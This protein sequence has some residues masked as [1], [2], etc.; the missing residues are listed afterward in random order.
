MT[1]V[2]ELIDI[3]E[4]VHRGDFVLKL[5]EDVAN[6]DAVI[7]NYVVTPELAECFDSALSF[8]K[9]A[10]LNRTSKATYLHG[11]FGSGKSHFMAVLHL[12]LQGNAKAR[13]MPELAD[14]IQKHNSWMQ[15]KKYLLVPYHLLGAHDMES[16]VLGSYVSYMRKTHEDAP[17][18]PV[19][20]SASLIDE[21]R[22][23]RRN[24]GDEAFFNR[25]NSV[26]ESSDGWG[27]LEAS[28]DAESFEKAAAADPESESHLRLVSTL[29]K[30]TASS[31]AEVI[32]SRG[33]NFVRFD[34]GL[35]II[36]QHAASI[37]Y[38]AVLLFLDELILWLSQHSADLGFVKSQAA[39]LTSLVEAQ[40]ADRPIPLISF[41]ARQRD[42]RN[43]IGKSVPGAER[44]SFSDSLDFQQGRFETITLED[45]NLPTIAEKRVLK[46][47]SESARQELDAA[48]EQTARMRDSVMNI[49]L[50][51]DG[52]REMFRKV[53][54]FSPALMQTLIAVSSVL[55][56]ERTALKVMLQLL[57]DQREH[58]KV[59]DV[60]PV[61]DLFDIIS[62]GDEA[63]SQEMAI[64]FKNAERLYHQKLLP[65]LQ[66]D[67]GRR[68]DIEQLPYDDPKRVA[69][70]NDDRLVKTLLLSALVPEVESLR[71]LTAERLAA[72]NH[73]TIKTPIPGRE[74][75]EVLRRVRN[76]AASVGEIRI[77]EETNPTISVQLS[78][79]D[80]ESIIRQAE[81]EDNQGNRIRRVRQML[82]E[83]L[84]V[85][86]EGEFEQFHDFLW[87]NT[88]RS[89]T[90]LFKNIRELGD[91]SLINSDD[92]WKLIIDFPFDEAGHTPK[93]DLAR[94]Q[95]FSD[96]HDSGTKTVCWVPQFFSEDARKD[97]GLLVILEHILTGERFSQY[98]THLSA[99]DRQAAKSLL[100]NQRS[101]LKQRVQNHLDAAYGLEAISAGSLDTTHE[102]D[103]HEQFI[104]LWPGFQPRPP[105]AANLGG[106]MKHLVSQAL[107][108]EFPAAPEFLAETKVTNL[109]KVYEVVSECARSHEPRVKVD[110]R[111]RGL[112]AQIANPLR[113]GEMAHDATH[114]VIGNH[115]QDHFDR[116]AAE[117][118]NAISVENLREWIDQP[119]AMGLPREVANM[120]ILTYADQTN[121]SFYRHNAPIDVSLAN[122]PDDTELKLEQ[123]PES[124]E[125]DRAV[126]LA[127]RIFG[128]T[129]SPLRNARNVSSLI[130][131]VK[132]KAAEQR[133]AC[134]EY[135]RSLNSRL[136]ELSIES[137]TAD[138]LKSCIDS[139]SLLDAIH[140]V[141]D[142]SVISVLAAAN[143]STSEA[144]VDEC[145]GK[146]SQMHA[147]L[148][149]TNWEIFDA[150]SKLT[151]DRKEEALE[152]GKAVMVAV[153]SD[154]HAVALAPALQLAQSK[155]LRLIVDPT[156]P[157]PPPPLPDLELV[158]EK[159]HQDLETSKVK[160]ILKDLEEQLAENQ[161]IKADLTYRI[162]ER[163]KGDQ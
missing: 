111:I 20:M 40:A 18:P 126:E 142:A 74:G 80:T 56:R 139:V 27:D 93:S 67:H 25:L 48:F 144:A 138:R 86:G 127:A 120:I 95:S 156:P 128:V 82:F 69:F 23:E 140:G 6:P 76:W 52:D 94:L 92:H 42:L 155:A 59:G 148:D 44:L 73:G 84:A 36:S 33:G 39:K 19:Y 21:A 113:L 43:L 10:V 4:R 153:S 132:S 98:S 87:R 79:V 118:G 119:R 136:R 162:Y 66:K 58:L 96:E 12:I 49:L 2:K 149:S 121:R 112:V 47:K 109:R 71:G 154:E 125:W 88:K 123:L 99:T 15:G 70:R 50:T 77:G 65:M 100:E 89:C 55:Q 147:T 26:S 131:T 8:I 102:I 63:F 159:S 163:K 106:A 130:A 146:A 22:G 91:S 57:V 129:V 35:S 108:S 11:S 75:Q 17:I 31:H 157:P 114:F 53:Y 32:S 38:D 97:L 72:L 83:Q 28:W 158:D 16:G 143:F 41:V 151:D 34:S 150:I 122:L 161:I 160:S 46:A 64:H 7:D 115:W 133:E 101:V 85:D 1:F 145:I 54:P 110:Q 134:H 78:G 62:H 51:H 3:P 103:Q 81:G 45:R 37:G 141:D 137:A 117:T 105:V 30:T 135:H 29:L 116:K 5:T 9:N 90:I 14:V 124:D 152:I 13:A 104:S 107:E 68:E 60:V 61:G 24:Y